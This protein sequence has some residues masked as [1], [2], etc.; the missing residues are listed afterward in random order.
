MTIHNSRTSYNTRTIGF[1]LFLINLCL[2]YFYTTTTKVLL[3]G[4]NFKIYLCIYYD[5][6][7]NFSM[8]YP[9][10][11]V[12]FLSV[13]VFQMKVC[14]KYVLFRDNTVIKFVTHSRV[15]FSIPCTR[16]I[17]HSAHQ[18]YGTE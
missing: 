17:N 14:W 9:N 7:N 5:L 13:I 3:Y 6:S 15:R 8:Y 10:V 2:M 16:E 18:A 4:S 11:L 12:Y 1:L